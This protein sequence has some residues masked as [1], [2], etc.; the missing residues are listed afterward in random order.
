MASSTCLLADLKSGGYA[1]AVEARFRKGTNVVKGGELTGDYDMDQQFRV[2]EK[3]RL[4]SFLQAQTEAVNLL[5]GAQTQSNPENTVI[6]TMAGLDGGGGFNLTA[7]I[8]MSQLA[9]RHCQNKN[10]RQRIIIFAGRVS[11]ASPKLRESISASPMKGLYY[12]V[13]YLR[14]GDHHRIYSPADWNALAFCRTDVFCERACYE[15]DKKTSM[16]KIKGSCLKGYGN[17]VLWHLL[18]LV[19]PTLDPLRKKSD[20]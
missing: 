18:L 2:G 20:D 12:C 5:R 14:P 16:L 1:K 9:L 8:Q 4:L 15:K 10:Q 6:L 13:I 17:K 7:A 19:L 3:R 11:L